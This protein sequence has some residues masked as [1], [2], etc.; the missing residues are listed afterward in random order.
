M[1]EEV[2]ATPFEKVAGESRRTCFVLAGTATAFQRPLMTPGMGAPENGTLP[3][4]VLRRTR[5]AFF[6]LSMPCL[7][8]TITDRHNGSE[9]TPC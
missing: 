5:P 7:I 1:R 6:W 4:L 3:S 8:Y 9:V 2:N